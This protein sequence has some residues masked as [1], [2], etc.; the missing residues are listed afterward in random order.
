MRSAQSSS[1]CPHSRQPSQHALPNPL[2]LEL[3]ERRQDVQLQPT[4][5]SLRI[6]P[7]PETREAD[8]HR[9]QFL[10]QR[11]QV[12]QVAPESV[13]APNHEHIEAAATGS[14]E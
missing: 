12:L 2:A 4:R 9:L 13:E 8:S 11:D 3:S 6:D 1:R 5:W 14:H 7:L 10:E